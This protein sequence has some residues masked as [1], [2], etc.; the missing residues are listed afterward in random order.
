[1]RLTIDPFE[2]HPPLIVDA[3]RVKVLQVASAARPRRNGDYASVANDEER[4]GFAI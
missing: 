3:D 2:D 4:T 1:M